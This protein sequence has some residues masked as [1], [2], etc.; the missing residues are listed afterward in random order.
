MPEG[1]GASSSAVAARPPHRVEDERPAPASP[2][3]ARP[4]LGDSRWVVGV[5]LAAVLAMVLLELLA[6]LILPDLSIGQA[7][8]L[9]IGFV[10]CVAGAEAGR[11]MIRIGRLNRHSRAASAS[12]RESER[13]ARDAE[14]RRQRAGRV[15]ILSVSTPSATT[16]APAARA[17]RA[18]RTRTS[19]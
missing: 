13:R 3:D 5:G 9:T 12:R 6:G 7:R 2:A 10:I 1:T 16:V 14:H 17:R 15:A 18:P 4:G 11:I 19:S 8:W